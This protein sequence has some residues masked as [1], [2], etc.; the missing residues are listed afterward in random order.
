MS[1]SSRTVSV[2]QRGLYSLQKFKDV[3]KEIF[4]NLQTV[5][6]TGKDEPGGA[7]KMET[8]RSQ[9]ENYIQLL[10]SFQAELRESVGEL[11][12]IMECKRKL[13]GMK[14]KIEDHEAALRKFGKGLKDAECMLSEALQRSSDGKN[15]SGLD[16][17]RELDIDD[18][19]HY[20]HL[21][22]YSTGAQ[23]GWEPNTVLN[24]A[25]PPAPH[26]EMMARSRLFAAERPS[27]M[28][29]EHGVG[30]GREDKTSHKE[31]AL[32]SAPGLDGQEVEAGSST[33]GKRMPYWR[34]AGEEDGMLKIWS[35]P[36]PVDDLATSASEDA[37]AVPVRPDKRQVV[38]LPLA[39]GMRESNARDKQS[40]DKNDAK[41][42]DGTVDGGSENAGCN[43]RE[44][45]TAGFEMPKMPAWWRPGMPIT[46]TSPA[47]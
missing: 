31:E 47:K 5:S 15:F 37:D 14:K 7:E 11:E 12:Q 16:E 46:L 1:S 9:R 22:S 13:G 21:I 19:I 2:R 38:V 3:T 32:D 8:L 20:S 26:S 17:P 36:L 23:E 39:C 45:P 44:E 35:H 40:Q 42:R 24:G 34:D 28:V 18:L 43:Q 30:M 41:M 25:L 27:R 33:L 10:C 6:K 4:R 29:S